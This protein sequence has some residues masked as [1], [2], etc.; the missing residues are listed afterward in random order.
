MKSK[1]LNLIWVVKRVW[2]RISYREARSLYQQVQLAQENVITREN[3]LAA[4]RNEL[5]AP[6]NELA[7]TRNELAATRNELISRENELAHSRNSRE[8]RIHPYVSEAL[9]IASKNTQ[10]AL[11]HE[12][13]ATINNLEGTFNKYGSDKESRHSYALTYSEILQGRKNPHILEI[14]LGSLN[15]FPYGGLPPGGSIKAWREAY[16]NSIIVGAD[17]DEEAVNSISEIGIVVDQTSDESLD[18]FV[19]KIAKYA[20][21]DLIVDDG[22]HDPHANLRTL[23]KVFPLT[24]ESGVYVIEDIH[25]SMVDLWRLLSLTVDADLE[26]RD[27]SAERPG[28]DDNILLIFKKKRQA[29]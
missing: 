14:G 15:G 24:A 1:Y 25:N 17:I 11:T 23:M 7:T 20:P 13:E 18:Q 26:I 19:T 3:E 21:F 2:Q 5:A 4:P 6:R 9:A 12:G 16:P 22:F 8:A 29:L 10:I 27:L 28:T